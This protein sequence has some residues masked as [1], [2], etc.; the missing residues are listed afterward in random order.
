MNSS[1]VP[2]TEMGPE[3]PRSQ[4]WSLSWTQS[5]G[6]HKPIRFKL[7]ESSMT[8]FP[9]SKWASEFELPLPVAT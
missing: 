1:V 8:E 2:G 7:G 9:S 3:D 4:S 6:A 5:L